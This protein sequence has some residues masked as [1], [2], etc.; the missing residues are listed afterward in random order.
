M[1]LSILL[2]C[3][4]SSVL[5]LDSANE[6]YDTAAED[7]LPFPCGANIIEGVPMGGV[8]PYHVALNEEGV[9]EIVEDVYLVVEALADILGAE[10]GTDYVWYS[11]EDGYG[12][13]NLGPNQQSTSAANV[14]VMSV[15]VDCRVTVYP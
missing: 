11:S 15:A 7:G 10:G 13:Y 2:A 4:D 5:D 12:I 9:Y 1:L 8:I 6:F 14:V 3:S